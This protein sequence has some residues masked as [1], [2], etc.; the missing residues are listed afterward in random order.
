MQDAADA[1]VL[2]TAYWQFKG[3]ADFTCNGDTSE[4][5]YNADGSLQ[6]RKTRALS[7]SYVHAYQG[8]PLMFRFSTPP[9]NVSHDGPYDPAILSWANYYSRKVSEGYYYVKDTLRSWLFA[10]S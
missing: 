4:G 6:E 3:F 8:I 5:F 2:S 7:R 1:H 9:N 10:H